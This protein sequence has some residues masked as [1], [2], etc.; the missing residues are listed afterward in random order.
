LEIIEEQ[1]EDYPHVKEYVRVLRDELAEL[2]KSE[3]S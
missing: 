1:D 2:L 3:S